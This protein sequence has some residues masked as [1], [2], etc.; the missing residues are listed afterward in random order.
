LPHHISFL[1]SVALAPPRSRP[2]PAG[3]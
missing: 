1:P 3:C 2:L